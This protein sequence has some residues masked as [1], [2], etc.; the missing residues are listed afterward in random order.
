MIVHGPWSGWPKRWFDCVA[1]A[2]GLFLLAPLLALIAATIRLAMGPPVVFR[3]QR[4][5]L[6]GRPFTLYKFRT[7]TDTFDVDG[8]L[9]PE[10]ERV[11]QLG[12]LLRRTSVDELPELFNVIKGDMSL[13]GPRPLL[14]RYLERYTREQFRRHEARPGITGLAQLNGRDT[15]PWER[16]FALDVWYVDNQSFWLDLRILL[17]T[18]SKTIVQ[19]DV[20]QPGEEGIAE[21]QGSG[22]R[23]DPEAS[24]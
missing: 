12:R 2:V 14:M 16:R 22:G 21:F 23:T 10:R 7:M 19:A 24:S 5:G 9:L 1:A 11:T 18:V 3:Q 6:H 4:P 17:R 15:T 8:R 20:S 13:V